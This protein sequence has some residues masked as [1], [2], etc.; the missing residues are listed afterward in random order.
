M[1]WNQLCDGIPDLTPE[2][3]SAIICRSVLRP[4]KDHK[5][6][7]KIVAYCPEIKVVLIVAP[8]L[9]HGNV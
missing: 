8:S 9:E 2:L 3:A 6:K 7:G 4:N 1:S 5:Q